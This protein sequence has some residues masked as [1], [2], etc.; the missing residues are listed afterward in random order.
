MACVCGADWTWMTLSSVLRTG[1]MELIT[2]R[3]EM[4][5]VHGFLDDDGDKSVLAA[6]VGMANCSIDVVKLILDKGGNPHEDEILQR[7]VARAS[8]A[9]AH[10]EIQKRED[11]AL[12]LISRGAHGQVPKRYRRGC[13]A[14]LAAL[15]DS[16]NAWVSNRDAELAEEEHVCLQW[17]LDRDFALS[18]SRL[19]EAVKSMRKKEK[20]LRTQHL[21]QFERARRRTRQGRAGLRSSLKSIVG[22][23]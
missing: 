5:G 20:W 16:R 3:L 2:E 12:F 7:A 11:I 13:P 1:D 15:L 19:R 14:R 10:A 22:D 6:V 9:V 21:G 17:K 23:E 4:E 8:D 18:T